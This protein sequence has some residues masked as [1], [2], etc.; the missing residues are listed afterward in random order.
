MAKR[1]SA[2]K[3]EYKGLIIQSIGYYHPE[4][5]ICWEAYDPIKGNADFHGFSKKEV[6]MWID[7]YL[8]IN[9]NGNTGK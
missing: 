5:R 2:G 9:D 3:Y 4:K 1:I 7:K 6:M 8:K